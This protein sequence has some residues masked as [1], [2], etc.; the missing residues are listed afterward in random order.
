MGVRSWPNATSEALVAAR[1]DAGEEIA[2]GLVSICLMRDESP[3]QERH[4]LIGETEIRQAGASSS[5]V[6]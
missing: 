6:L 2:S 3:H 1:E 5:R 4:V